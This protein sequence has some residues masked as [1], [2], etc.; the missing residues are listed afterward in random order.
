MSI[1]RRQADHVDEGRAR[2]ELLAAH[3]VAAAAQADRAAPA[4]RTHHD[5]LQLAGAR[6]LQHF[7]HARGIQLRMNVVDHGRGASDTAARDG[8][9]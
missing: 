9:R 2:P 5:V 6:R 4:G 8:K 1:T 7:R 3:R